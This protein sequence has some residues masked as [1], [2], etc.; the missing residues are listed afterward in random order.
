MG[1]RA[2]LAID[3]WVCLYQGAILPFWENRIEIGAVCCC[4]QRSERVQR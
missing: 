4:G 3:A 1:M 2:R